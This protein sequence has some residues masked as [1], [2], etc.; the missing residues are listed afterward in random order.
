MNLNPQVSDSQSNNRILSLVDLGTEDITPE[1][2]KYQMQIIII[3]HRPNSNADLI[4]TAVKTIRN[5]TFPKEVCHNS[6][7][8][9]KEY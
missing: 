2:N 3:D 7:L 6:I 1:R 5:P 4:Q 8:S 9:H